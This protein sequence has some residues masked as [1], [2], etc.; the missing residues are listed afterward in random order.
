MKKF[1]LPTAGIFA[2][3]LITVFLFRNWILKTAVETSVTGLTG[4][5]TRIEV[6]RY[7]FPATL[8]I[9]GLTLQ[10]PGGFKNKIS[11]SIPEIYIDLSLGELLRRER[12]H[13]RGIKLNIGE[14]HVEKN[15]HG[16]TNVSLLRSAG[17]SAPRKQTAPPKKAAP[18]RPAM[19]FLLDRLELTLRTVTFEDY[20]AGKLV[21]SAVRPEKISVDMKVEKEVFENIQNPQALV[22]LVLLK[23]VYGTT[24]GNLTGLSPG[25]LQST[26]TGAVG[27]GKKFLG[28]T[29]GR[30]TEKAEGL[31]S[32]AGNTAAQQA[33]EFLSSRPL[34]D[35]KN[36]F[37]DAAEDTKGRI[38]GFVNKLKS[39]LES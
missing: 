39:N 34:T 10:N 2:L 18:D 37:A 16:V 1:L 17:G 24:F 36:T 25:K 12:V 32:G 30:M 11:A 8:E 6:F 33:Q 7:N 35:A 20:S 4:F 15:A 9:K 21:P 5:K 23:I 31:V 38:S 26:L 14:V 13:L 22:N 19:P 3:L 29:A 27:S 28:Q